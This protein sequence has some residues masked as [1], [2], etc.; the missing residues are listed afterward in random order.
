MK[1]QLIVLFGPP[2]C[3]KGTQAHE[4]E[5]KY[6]YIQLGMSALLQEYIDNSEDV[7]SEH[8]RVLRIQNNF[9]KGELVAFEDVVNIMEMN[10]T[11]N[12]RKG[13][14]MTLDGFP[15]TENQSM[16]LSGL[17]TKE[18]VRTLFIHF[19]LGLD[20]V[21]RRID[22]RWFLEGSNEIFASQEDALK[23]A[24]GEQKPFK[25]DL[26]LDPKIIIKRYHEQYQDEKSEIILGIKNNMFVDVVNIDASKS[27]IEVFEHIQK[28]L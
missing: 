24:K 14:T 22:H 13:K 11:K 16:W 12:L 4:L 9:K 26:D 1:Y 3:G 15:R 18:K 6:N 27:I 7:T 21:Q 17:I 10:F 20:E 28:K 5:L 19:E 23:H 2:G 8:P 25:R